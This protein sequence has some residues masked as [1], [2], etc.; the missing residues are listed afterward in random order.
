MDRFRIGID[1]GGT[2]TDAV[3]MSGKNILAIHKTPTTD[4][5]TSGVSLA[6]AEILKQSGIAP[7]DISSVMI[8]TTHFINAII[9]H[10]QLQK[11]A[12]IRLC[13]PA[14]T[15]ILPYSDWPLGLAESL[16]KLFYLVGGGC[17]YDGSEIAALDENKLRSI[18]KE[19]KP[20]NIRSVAITGVFSHVNSKMEQQA[21]KII[22]EEIS[23][24]SISQSHRIGRMG[25]LE[26]ENAT[27]LNAVLKELA[28]KTVNTFVESLRKSNIS[29]PLYIC[30]NDGTLLNE[31]SARQYPILTC[32]AGPT[33]SLRGAAFLTEYKDAMVVDI[34]GTT[35]DVGMLINGYPRESAMTVN[36]GGVRTNFP[37]PDVLSLG[38]GGGSIIH[39]DELTIG[40]DSVGLHLTKDALVF[41]GDTLTATDIAVANRQ[42]S[43]GDP[44]KIKKLDSKLVSKA[45]KK[46]HERVENAV[47]TMKT[48]IKPLP[49][50]LVG[51]GSIL[52]NGKLEGVS[53]II[54]PKYAEIANAVGAAIGQ[55]AG[56]YDQIYRYEEFPR[57][58]ALE[59]AK[60]RAK[61]EA[62][63]KGAQ[64]DTLFIHEILE[65]PITYL[66]GKSTRVRVKAIGG[67][68]G[69]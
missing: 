13:L 49:L 45:I 59:E 22:G 46:I 52:I 65:T 39:D 32:A 60:E 15:G 27:I 29:A 69:N 28:E 18:A 2:N 11:V 63:K 20:K 42:I 61:Q 17:E 8:G 25:L 44:N 40:P 5:V 34:G 57:E 23:N 53:E 31:E 67:L 3:L 37:M 6:I 38:L 4:D 12:V 19:I 47:D 9:Q 36:I 41:G 24:I 14:T 35:S 43:I 10:K 21:A 54:K 30:Q 16:G 50:I 1:V 64:P 55:V 26:R 7:S 66:P 51:G 33:N 58:K 68:C 56:L 48:S 62:I